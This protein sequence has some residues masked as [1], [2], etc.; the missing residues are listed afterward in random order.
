MRLGILGGT[1]NPIHLGHLLLAESAREQFALD[2]VWFMPAAAPPHKSSR[3]LLGG[4]QRFRLVQAAVKG[5]PK[6][7]TSDLELR[8]GG[9]SY[10]WRTLQALRARVPAARL[11]WIVGSDLLGVRWYRM[12][13]AARLCT[14]L[15]AER[16]RAPAGAAILGMRR[17][18]MPPVEIS[19]SEI[20]ARIRQGRSIRY[21]VPDAV[22]RA[23]AR[24]R[25]YR[26]GRR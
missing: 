9:V 4:P 13:D 21:L 20:R 12:D 3:D 16:G 22:A 7:F 24:G 10:T 15:V 2:R 5:Y 25:F 23:I 11:F 8:L 1:F 26:G 14:F 17:I 18:R 6:F 19:S